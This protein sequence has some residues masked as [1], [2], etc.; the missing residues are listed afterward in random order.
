MLHELARLLNQND[1]LEPE[2]MRHAAAVLLER[3]FLFA[4]N[5]RDKSCYN[6]VIEHQEYYSNLFDA[7][8][9][10]LKCV[11]SAGYAG[12]VPKS[13]DTIVRLAKDQSMLLLSLRV[14]Y[15]EHFQ[16][17]R[18]GDNSQ[19]YTD[20]E[21]LLTSYVTHTGAKRPLLG[22]LREIITTFSRQG[23]VEKD[24]D[25]EKI[26]KFRIRPSIREVVTEGYLKALENYVGID[27]EPDETP[28]SENLEDSLEEAY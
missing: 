24:E 21:A 10:E 12:I 16:E 15:E 14:I 11:R 22:R 23:I 28:L 1:T 27:D 19:A 7:F 9:Y 26:I 4:D 20:S 17:C 6:T 25:D 2:E 8:N 3:Q 5:R 13:T 18:L